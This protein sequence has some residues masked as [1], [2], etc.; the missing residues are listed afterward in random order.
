MLNIFKNKTLSLLFNSRKSF[1]KLKT[2]SFARAVRTS[3]TIK[4]QE[5]EAEEVKIKDKNDNVKKKYD[6]ITITSEIE[7][8]KKDETDITE[9]NFFEHSVK[10]EISNLNILVKQF[11]QRGKLFAVSMNKLKNINLNENILE[12]YE[13]IKKNSKSLKKDQILLFIKGVLY[14]EIKDVY[15]LDVLL[16]FSDTSRSL[17][18]AF[19]ILYSFAKLDYMNY[20]KSSKNLKKIETYNLLFNKSIEILDLT[21][22]SY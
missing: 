19:C 20:L 2:V 9:E 7:H 17:D 16:K 22:Y 12:D 6:H 4:V 8:E 1:L 18:S 3:K 10:R 21:V 14:Y 15:F 5:G 11:Y 13:F